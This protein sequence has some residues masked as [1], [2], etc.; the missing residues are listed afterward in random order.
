MKPELNDE[1]AH[2]CN[3][4]LLYTN[5]LFGD[6]VSKTA[7]EIEYTAKISNKLHRSYRGG[8]RARPLARGPRFRGRGRRLYRGTPANRYHPY[9]FGGSSSSYQGPK[10]FPRRGESKT[11]QKQ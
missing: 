3:H 7:K 6:D 10:N 1:Y 8:Y 11:G 4:S 2:L 5:Y 9:G